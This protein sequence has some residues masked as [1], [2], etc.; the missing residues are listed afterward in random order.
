MAKQSSIIK[1]EGTIDDLTFYKS[2]NG[3]RVRKKTGVN[4]ERIQSDPAFE[5]TRENQKEFG[6]VART[7]KILRRSMIDLLAEVSDDTLVP[8]MIRRLS[9]IRNLD[10]NS[11]RGERTVTQGLLSEEGKTLLRGFDFN[12]EAPL[13]QVL[14]EEIELDTATGEMVLTDFNPRKH[15]SRPEGATHVA[16]RAGFLNVDFDTESADLQVSPQQEVPLQQSVSTITLT[17]PAAPEGTGT[18]VHVLL[19]EYYQEL[20]EVMYPLNSGA[21]NALSIVEV[22]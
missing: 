8:R 17:P 20:N 11:P 16:F 12:Q 13:Q 6:I 10:T 19:V 15:L 21:F 7:G 4:A 14:K 22:A 2:K 3:Y 18:Q 9:K 5:R 1:I